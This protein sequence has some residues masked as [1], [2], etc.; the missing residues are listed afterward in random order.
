ME[1]KLDVV[2]STCIKQRKPW[3]RI[4][5]IGQEKEAI[6]LLDD[7]RINEINL[8]SGKTKKKIPQLQS[9]L[10]NVVVLTTSRNGAWLAGVLTTGELFLWNKDRDCLKIVPTV[11]ESRKAVAAAQECLMRLYLFVS[12]DGRKALLTTPAACVLLWE[13]TEH[14]NTSSPKSSSGRWTQIL[15]DE[16]VMLP[17]TEQKETGVHAAFIQN[18]ILG[19]CCL[20]SFVFY[21]GE[22]LVLTFLIIRWHEN[23]FK[24]V[25][26]LPYQIHWVQQTCSLVNLVPQCVS[27]KSRGGLLCAFARD[28]LLLA[29][30]VNQTDPQ[31]TQILFLNTLNFVT[32]SGSLKG[33]SSKSNIPS[34]FIRSYWV[35]DMSWTPDSL[36]LACMLKRGSLILLTCMGE[37]LTL[38]TTGCSVEFGPAE[39]IP[40]HPLI[41]YRQQHS[42]CQDS[43][44]SLG[45]SASES[46]LMRQR[47]SVASHSRLPYLIISDGYMV[48][49]LRFPNNLSPSGFVRSLLLDST[50][51]LENIRQNLLNSK[52]KGRHLCLRSLLSL[53]ASL[54]QHA[55]NQSSIFSTIPKFL[56]EDT[57]EMSEKTMDLLDYE[58]ESDDRKQFCNSPSHFYSQRIHSFVAK[59]DHGH[60]EFASM[61]DTI[62][63]KDN[64]EEKD[65]LS[66]ELYTIQKNLL[67]AWQIGISKNEEEKDILLNYT[68][69]CII[70]FFNILQF[71]KCSLLNQD[72]STNKSAKNTHWMRCVLNCFQQCLNVL[73]WHSRASLTG[74]VTKMTLQTL[75]LM[76]VQQQDQLFSKNLLACFCLL[77]MVSH[78]LSSMCI[79]QYENCFA[80]PHGNLVELDS[81][82]VPIFQVLDENTPQQ[83]SSLKSLLR[84]PPQAV[85]HDAKPEKRLI[86]LWQLLYKKVVWY[87]MQL[88]REVS[89]NAEEES[90]VSSLISHIQATLQSSG[91]TLEKHLKINSVSGEEKFLLGSYRESVDIWKRSLCE[92]KAKGGK[93]TYFLQTRYY[94]AI[95]F[96]HLYQ[97]NLCE[98]QGLCDH[99]VGE[100]LRRSQ[101]SR[102]Q[103]EKFSDTKYVQHELWMVTDVHTETAMAVIRSMA[104]FMAAYFTDQLL[105]IF[106]PHSVDILHPLHMKQVLSPR[107][108]PLQHCL[109]TRAVRDQNLSSVWTVEYALDLFFIGG[110]IPEA[111]WLTHRLGDWK[112]SVSIGVAYQLYCQ[113]SDEFS[114]LKN[115]ECHLPLSLSPLQTFQ[116]KL[117]SLLG[118]PV[119]SETSGC[120]TYKQFTDPIEEEDANVLYSSIQ[121]LL[122]AAVM[123][124]ADILSETI[125]L[126][127]NSAKDLSRKLHGLVPDGLYLPA[128]PLYCPQPSSLSEEDCNDILL[129]IER[130]S[131]QRL[132]GVLQRIILLFWAAQC[133][134][135]AAQ[136]YIAQLKWA[137]KVMQ[138]IR[139]KASL[140]LLSPFPETLLRYSHFRTVFCRRTPSGDHQFDDI[141]CKILGWFR[142][143]C[144][145]CWMFHVRERLSDNCRRY[146][147]ARENISNHK[148][149]KKN[150]YDASTVE[151]CLKAVEWACRML[152]FCRFMNVEE[153]V[154]DVILSLLGELPPV[155][156]VAEIFVKAFPSPEDVR[157]PLRDKYHGLQ[158]RLRHS[159]VKGTEGEEMMSVVIQATEKVRMKAL[160]LVIRNIGPIETNIWEPAEEGIADDVEHCYERFSSGTSLS[161]STLTD[162]GNPQ[163]YSDADTA[164]T[165]S[166]DLFTEETRAQTP[167]LQR[168][169]EHQRQGEIGSENTTCNIKALNWKTKHKNKVYGK[170]MHNQY[171]LPIV[172]AWEFERDDDEYIIFLELF[173]SYVVERDLIKYSDLG[174]PFLTSFSGLLREHELNSLVFDVHTTLKRRQGK[175]RSQSVFRAGSC[176]TVTLVSCD[177]ETVS[178][179][180][181]N[182]NIF[183]NPKVIHSVLQTPERPVHNLMKRLN[184]GLFGLKHKSIYRAQSYNQG[185]TVA[186]T[187]QAFPNHTFSSLQTQ[188]ISK[189]I[190]KTVDTGDTVPREELA[191]VLM[192]KLSNIAKLL[193]WMIRWSDKKLLC[194]T[195]NQDSLKEVF[196][197]MHVKTSAAAVLTSLW[198]LEHLDRDGS[199]AKSIKSKSPDN[200]YRKEFASLSEAQSRTE[201]GSSVDKGS[202]I[203]N[204]PP[205]DVQSVQ[206]YGDL[207]ETSFGMSTNSKYSDKKEINHG[208]DSLP[209]MTEELDEV[210]PFVQEELDVTSQRE[211]FFEEPYETP[212]SS[213]GSVKIK[214]VEHRR[215]KQI[216]ISDVDSPQQDQKVEET[217]EGMAE[218]KV[219]TEVVTS[220]TSHS[221]SLEQDAEVPSNTE[222]S[223]SDSQPSQTVMSAVSSVASNTSICAKK[224]EVKEEVPTEEKQNTSET[225]RQMLQDEMFKLVQLQQINFMS[226]MQIVQSSFANL[227]NVQ[228]ILQQHQ[229]VHLEGSQPAHTAEG[230]ASLKTQ[231]PT[232]EDKGKPG[233]KSSDF[234]PRNSLRDES[235]N[236]HI[237]NHLDVNVSFNLLESHSRGTGFM[238][239]SQDLHSSAP[240]K[241]LHLLAPSADIQKTPKL[242]PIEKSLNYSK[243]FPLLKLKSGY[244]FKPAFLH[245]IEVSSAF[246]RPPPVPRVAWGS[247]DPLWN[248]QSSYAPGKSKSKDDLNMNEYDSEIP[249]QMHE[250]EKTWAEAVHKGPLKLLNLDQ[251]E[252][253]QELSPEQQFSADVNMDKALITQNLSGIPLL[254]LDPVPQVPPVV[255][256]P[257]TTT[258]IPVKPAIKE[259]DCRGTLQHIGISLLRAD[260]SQKKKAPKLIPLQ[261]L[262]AFEQRHQHHTVSGT[263]FGQ[264]QTEPIQLL[265]TDV[266][267]F[268]LRQVQSNRKRQKRRDK[269]QM[270]E[271][272]EKKK[273]S[274][275]FCPDDTIISIR[276]TVIVVESETEDQQGK[277]TS[278]LQDGFFISVDTMG[279]AITTSADVHYMASTEKKTAETQDASTNTH[280]ALNSYQD[281]GISDGNEVSEVQK[282]ESVM[283]V[284]VSEST[285]TPEILPPDMYLNLRLPTEVNETPL[286]SFLSH[287]SGLSEHE[288]ISVI[289]IEDKDILNNLPVIPESAE[290]IATAQQNEQ[291]EI[292][293]TEK[294]HHMAASV[295]NAV[296]PKALQKKDDLKNVS[297]PVQKEDKELPSARDSVTWNVIH[298]DDR[299]TPSSGLP[300][301]VIGKNYFS[302]K[303]QEMYMRL[304]T[305]QN[306]TENMEEDFR[307]TKL[308]VKIIE[309]FEM[310]ANSDLG[311][312][313]SFS[314][315]DRI[316][317]DEH[318]LRGLIFEDITDDE[319]DRLNLEYPVPSYT[320]LEVSSPASSASASNFRNG[321]KSSSGF[322]VCEDLCDSSLEDPLRIT[323]LSGVTDIISDLVVEGGIS[324]SELDFTKITAKKIS[325]VHDSAA[326]HSQK[327]E[328]KKKEI[329]A[330]MKRKQKERMREY[331]KKLD[332][333]RQK[334]HNPFNLRKNVRCSLTSKDTKLFQKKKEE[335]DR[336]LLSEHHSMRITQALSLMNEMLPET[337]VLPENERRPSCRTRSPQEY[338]KGHVASTKGEYPNSPVVSE[339]SRIAAKSSFHQKIHRFTPTL[340][341]TQS[342]GNACMLPQKSTSRGRTRNA[343]NCPVNSRHSAEQRV[344]RTSKQK[345]PHVATAIETEGVDQETDR[346]IV[347]PWTVP[348][349][350]QRILQDT[351]DSLFQASALHPVSLS[352][353]GDVIDTDG[354]SESTGSIL[355]KL[356]WNAIEAM[357]ADVE[358]T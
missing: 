197:V 229:P 248:H 10:K 259:A 222:I 312:R 93:R 284:P 336:A 342:R 74:H 24:Y 68:V 66:V 281:V 133:S 204:S 26:S 113:N 126:L 80:S 58:E 246:A 86:V 320:A 27:V 282:N 181:E 303:Q 121:E 201:K 356:D 295:I 139:Q 275:S 148:D 167:S 180:N 305:L 258:L 349:D 254:K 210:R 346:D 85:N 166:E 90:V 306:I 60:L 341:L 131:R 9:L 208:T 298:E 122:K 42:L 23:S 103:M 83:F 64:T 261:D 75:K 183:A 19:D 81:L 260:L 156:K 46:D 274:V 188:A 205:L 28:G 117:Q 164:D 106:P 276:D 109:V 191:I 129:K 96:C 168:D 313:P 209:H 177:P 216:S 199:Q 130:Q 293:S 240:T 79:L 280:P 155:K 165:L 135:P 65:K 54:L 317:G 178:I 345:P 149:L 250:E 301:K 78:T 71:V 315:D 352:P 235:S 230:N 25:S 144:A 289:D 262:I 161:R 124:D 218:Q 202:S 329:Q 357:V 31:A 296:P 287:A 30:A 198:L 294:L 234:Q 2:I 48:T 184:E 73:Y 136:W 162:F 47:F 193:E 107:I 41:T 194:G 319:K 125:Q 67:A 309:D 150:E 119:T 220:T 302:A 87:Q 18:E 242:I 323:G 8:A 118:Q 77:K 269:K 239:P 203:L 314:E 88:N 159:I 114:R 236:G 32:V 213:D 211:E 270:E 324:P 5:W 255:R 350:I 173:L 286:P 163:V 100:I 61:F 132:S 57:T 70:H 21:S 332:E 176:Y 245:P 185:V 232:Q 4:S 151:H 271:K 249:R 187:S 29:V 252:G 15:P 112:L 225:V 105:Y 44:Q 335:K 310:A 14:G 273:S 108:I 214:S 171:N 84:E 334:E 327:T 243:G 318:Y 263:S 189:Y 127:M 358:D 321:I 147:T 140:P 104:R 82:T 3:P 102:S 7:K 6:F 226:L 55:Q 304:Q 268:K 244:H 59:A 174:I 217:K 143:L 51:R 251:H 175:T 265:K 95:L 355:S 69:N 241:S 288:Y 300:S 120:V 257:I 37:L 138:K 228:H 219:M 195:N 16:S 40:F 344:S 34:K 316:I 182:Q 283:S 311:T 231:L 347:S 354:V 348:D 325:R 154:Q 272:E 146:Q 256:Q 277:S 110:L 142:E 278:S 62:H 237:K 98:A 264:D 169:N 200:Q 45:S 36:F 266:E 331:M 141:T 328:K 52:S 1:I 326:R 35:G 128:P 207:F 299:T 38:I 43:S 153:L 157:V 170:D 94:L 33:C 351:H 186:P 99:L 221:F 111:V 39:F 224:Q 215:G 233:K 152:P 308:L 227:P 333:Q 17:S 89:K 253:Q 63:A 11:E 179:Y 20:C 76:L 290:E 279:E 292:P 160:R 49:V 267:P 56:E 206:P 307:N 196:P 343:A 338:R 134:C 50:E 339:R 92:I 72:A 285:T 116:E 12:G 192:D 97:Y 115:T 223:P 137:R 340:G 353:I 238:I 247:S 297:S 190:Y 145:L 212:K 101:L 13:S 172:G 53:K 158:Q 322:H 22:C 337:V 123:A 91:V 330:W 291:F